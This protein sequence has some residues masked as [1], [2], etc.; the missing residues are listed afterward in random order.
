MRSVEA[1]AW[2]AEGCMA[3]R[4]G[5]LSLDQLGAS[6]AGRAWPP[7]LLPGPLGPTGQESFTESRNEKNSL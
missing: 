2:G 3:G 7:S 4:R 5:P 1:E 6:S